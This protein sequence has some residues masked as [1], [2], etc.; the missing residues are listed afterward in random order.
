MGLLYAIE[1]KARDWSA[2]DRLALRQREAV[3]ILERLGAWMKTEYPKLPPRGAI[4]KALAYSIT[5]WKK[6]CL[7]STDGNLC[8]DN[9]PIYPNFIIIQ[10]SS[11]IAS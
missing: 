7:Y 8:I 5:R 6:L 9:N 2:D 1:E 4:A 11:L 3:P 10:T